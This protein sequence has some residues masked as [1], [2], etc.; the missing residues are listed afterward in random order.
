[1]AKKALDGRLEAHLAIGRVPP[2]PRKKIGV[3]I[4]PGHQM[5]RFA[6]ECQEKRGL[7]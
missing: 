4:V 3:E 5:G 7:K 6:S 1:M 2:K